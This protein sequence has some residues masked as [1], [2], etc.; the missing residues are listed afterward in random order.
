MNVG[1]LLGF[2]A[3]AVVLAG[4]AVAQEQGK[5]QG[6]PVEAVTV[7]PRPL[8][9]TILAVGSL[10]ADEAVMVRPEIDGRIAEIAFAEGERVEKGQVLLRLDDS[11]QKARLAKAEAALALSRSNYQRADQL[12][13]RQNMSQASRDEAYSRLRVD[14]AD[15]RAVAVELEKT[16]IKAPFSGVIGLRKVSVGAYV[17]PG[18]DVVDLVSLDP[19][20]VDFRV[21]EVFAGQV[22]PGQTVDISIDAFP[23]RTFTGEVYALDPQVDVNGR[24]MMLR[25]RVA[26][27]DGGA[28]GPLRPG[29]FARITLLL[30]HRPAAL[31]VPEQ[32]LV[33]RGRTQMVVKVIDG[34]AQYV[35][36]QIG[37]R[38]EGQVEIT[39][40]L[41]AGDVVV[42]AGQ[43]KLQPGAPVMVLPPPKQPAGT[44][45]A[46]PA[47][48]N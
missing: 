29:M 15:L 5:P 31:M 10:R 1:K 18:Q 38:A 28:I 7:Q 23:G 4:P 34:T 19:I 42:T 33:P 44:A 25:A 30:D 37:W 20:K 3:V 40:G 36:V 9:R 14:E 8:D 26:N 12:A 46:P 35:P 39:G 27:R 13:Q 24:S 21:P 32:A 48:Q 41:T 17:Q 16:V 43:I 2:L 22:T 47:A 6:L 11:T 45:A